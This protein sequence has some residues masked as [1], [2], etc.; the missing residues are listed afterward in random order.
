MTPIESIRMILVLALVFLAGF[1]FTGII[2]GPVITVLVYFVWQYRRKVRSLE[3]RLAKSTS[4]SSNVSEMPPKP[5]AQ[6]PPS[7]TDA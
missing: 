4:Q 1:L 5:E 6:L 2:G 3:D 7:S